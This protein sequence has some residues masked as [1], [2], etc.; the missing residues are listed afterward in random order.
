MIDKE[1]KKSI[2]GFTVFVI[3]VAIFIFMIEMGQFLFLLKN[4]HAEFWECQAIHGRA[5]CSDLLDNN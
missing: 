2:K 3:I 1:T 4:N 5:Q